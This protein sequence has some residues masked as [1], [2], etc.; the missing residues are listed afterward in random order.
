MNESRPG[1]RARGRLRRAGVYALILGVLLVLADGIGGA[2]G[3]LHPD[4][5]EWDADFIILA[6]GCGM[7]FLANRRT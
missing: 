1:R 2:A 5:L 3:L 4:R 6:A 7:M